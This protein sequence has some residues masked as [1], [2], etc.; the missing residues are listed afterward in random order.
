M[1]SPESRGGITYGV[2]GICVPGICISCGSMETAGSHADEP[3]EV[4][5]ELALVRKPDARGDLRQG[6][7]AALLHEQP[8]PLDASGNDKLM[9]WQ[10]RG[11]SELAR[12]MV[13]AETGL[14]SQ[15]LQ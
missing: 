1:V 14:R 12:E 13:R 8:C 9:R 4:A 7:V 5:G 10:S 11:R 15:F 6:D 2:P 3:F